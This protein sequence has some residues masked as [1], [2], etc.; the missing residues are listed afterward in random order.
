MRSAGPARP[1][2]AVRALVARVA[3]VACVATALVLGG[4]TVAAPAGA[5]VPALAGH[6][7]TAGTGIAGFNVWVYSSATQTLVAGTTTNATGDY[8]IASLAP[9]SYRVQFWKGASA[10]APT[11]HGAG[12]NGAPSWSSAAPITTVGGVT[13]IVDQ[14]VQVAGSLHGTV[15]AGGSGVAGTNVW[16]YTVP[17]NVWF[18]SATTDATGAYA[19]ASLLPG[20]YRAQAW[21]S[22][23]GFPTTWFG[24]GTSFASAADV[25][26]PA[27]GVATAAIDAPTTGTITGVVRHLG[28]GVGNIGVLL[29]LPSGTYV[30]GAVTDTGGSYTI[31][32]VPAGPYKLAFVDSTGTYPA[33]G[34]WPDAP[35][36]EDATVIT[37]V[38]GGV[39]TAD[40]AVYLPAEQP[41]PPYTG[42]ASGPTVAVLGDSITQLSTHAIHAALD[43]T[44]NVA[45]RGINNQ[46]IDQLQPVAERFAATD[47]QQVIIALGTNDAGQGQP[48]ADSEAA[49]ET[50]LATFPAAACI[51]IVTVNN[52]T[53]NA[54]YNG[55]ASALDT[56]LRSLPATHPQVQLF[57]WQRVREIY[58]QAFEPDGQWTTD[59]IHPTPLGQ[60]QYAAGMA[61]AVANCAAPPSSIAG[62]VLADVNG[63]G[64]ADPGEPPS[65]GVTMSLT[66]ADATGNAVSRTVITG[67]DGS[68]TFAELRAGTYA[69]RETV[70]AGYALPRIDLGSAGGSSH[71]PAIAG[72]TLA[73]G[74]D[75]VGYTFLNPQTS[76]SIGGFAYA[77]LDGSGA[78]NGNEPGLASVAVTLDGTDEQGDTIHV[79]TTTG[80]DGSWSFAALNPGTYAVVEATPNGFGAHGA[81]AG[82]LGGTVGD[83]RI[84]G[85]V[86]GAG[87]QGAGYLFGEVPVPAVAW[88]N[89]VNAPWG[90]IGRSVAADPAGNSYVT[91][92]FYGVATFGAGSGAVTLTSAGDCDIYLAKYGPDGNL[93]WAKRA[94]GT[95]ADEAL[96]VAV[97][98]DGNLVVAGDVDGVAT[99]GEGTAAA[100]L[101]AQ[102]D[103]FVAAYDTNGTLRW[104]RQIGGATRSVAS[105]AVIDASG[106]VYLT[107]WFAGAAEVSGT[108][109]TAPGVA[110]GLLARYR[111]DG[112]FDWVRT[113]TSSDGVL[114]FD[115]AVDAAGDAIV[116]GGAH[117]VNFGAGIVA[118]PSGG[119]GL[120]AFVVSFGADGTLGWSRS[121][122]DI[123]ADVVF[124]VAVDP[125]TDA[126]FV[127]GTFSWTVDFG[128]AGTPGPGPVLISRGLRDAF[129]MALSS[130][131]STRWVRAGGGPDDDMAARLSVGSGLVA[132]TGNVVGR[133]TFDDV[134]LPDAGA[135]DAFVA[136]Y[137]LDGRPRWIR[138]IAGPAGDG[139]WGTAVLPAGDV[140]AIGVSAGAAAVVPGPVQVVLNGGWLPSQY[141]TRLR[142]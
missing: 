48:L 101:N 126:L 21:S 125:A 11:W 42:L 85:I 40:E 72:I 93:V 117:A 127:S 30:T 100:T 135:G 94:G 107:G 81:T 22:T 140:V 82:P 50:M 128:A 120:D 68:W 108:V 113:F 112:T 136:A 142:A 58:W 114:P 35:D 99:F 65:A 4:L 28:V 121:F 7:D 87:A 86:L 33:I 80:T 43:A 69:V 76:S 56:Y 2:R 57:D 70:P 54:E 24:G 29:F 139:G 1:R 83:R 79:V 103:A 102:E 84:D 26:V 95:G 61:A 118:P 88:A 20:T 129:V 31:G 98:A 18:A 12:P 71:P 63:D 9:G 14:S 34:Y 134:T 55:R 60:V 25:V 91:G 96:K 131:G 38:A 78:R 45:V 90:S 44:A 5:V 23:A 19:F 124:G 13:T 73:A 64:V 52:S 92:L 74:T 89:R 111:N 27:A 130:D 3:L 110:G 137:D 104:V 122:G 133:P 116:G 123:G 51:T 47:P 39:I 8:T 132:I 115:V 77:D 138:S 6:V 15:S 36:A 16:L 17:G 119:G 105:S 32:S 59:S 66:G 46:R 75:A 37:V 109:V 62:T 106:A 49:L 10:F 141:L 41:I 97:N 53:S 67:A